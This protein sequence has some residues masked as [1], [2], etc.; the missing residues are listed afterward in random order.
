MLTEH[1]PTC[2][3]HDVSILVPG[4]VLPQGVTGTFSTPHCVYCEFDLPDHGLYVAKES[5]SELYEP[6][7]CHCVYPVDVDAEDF[8]GGPPM[9]LHGLPCPQHPEVS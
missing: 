6:H 7:G 4:H 8:I 9:T 1:A 2:P 5:M 3:G